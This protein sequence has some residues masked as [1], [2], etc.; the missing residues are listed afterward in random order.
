MAK[1]PHIFP[2]CVLTHSKTIKIQS[3]QSIASSDESEEDGGGN[4]YTVGLFF[5]PYSLVSSLSTVELRTGSQ[6]QGEAERGDEDY[7]HELPPA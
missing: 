1:L 6:A 4:L 2:N 5:N 3:A 7:K